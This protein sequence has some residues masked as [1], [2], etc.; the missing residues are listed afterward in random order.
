MA[1]KYAVIALVVL[2]L[3]G[4]AAFKEIG[5][6]FREDPLEAALVVSKTNLDTITSFRAE[7]CEPEPESGLEFTCYNIEIIDTSYTLAHNAA[8]DAAIRIDSDEDFTYTDAAIEALR[9]VSEAITITATID[10]NPDRV[11][12]LYLPARLGIAVLIQR[13]DEAVKK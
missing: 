6:A 2:A 4:C 8:V 11:G 12:N 13:L 3:S 9:G 10:D 1:Y 7:K 5:D